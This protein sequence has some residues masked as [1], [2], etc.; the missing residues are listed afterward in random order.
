MLDKPARRV[1]PVETEYTGFVIEDE[2]I[3]GYGLDY[4]QR[5]RNLPY[6]AYVSKADGEEK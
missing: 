1:K 3:L 4:E 2:F 6:I 5:Y